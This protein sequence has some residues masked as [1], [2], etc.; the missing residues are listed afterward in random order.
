MIAFIMQFCDKFYLHRLY[1]SMLQ[2]I[3]DKRDFKQPQNSP[4]VSVP[5]PRDEYLG[6]PS[7]AHLHNTV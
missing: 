1:F 5:R 7:L 6:P 3:S 2:N 4:Y